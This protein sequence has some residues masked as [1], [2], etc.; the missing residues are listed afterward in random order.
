MFKSHQLNVRPRR[1]LKQKEEEKAIFLKKNIP[2][3]CDYNSKNFLD[4][5]ENFWKPTLSLNIINIYK[6]YH[7][8]VV[9]NET[10][11]DYSG[12]CGGGGVD[13]HMRC[14]RLVLRVD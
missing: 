3:I 9:Q 7:T 10:L 12:E 14:G 8:H 5:V 4:D 11:H 6:P 13:E 2:G 1:G